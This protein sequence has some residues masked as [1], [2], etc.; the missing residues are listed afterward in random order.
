M[1][2]AFLLAAAQ[3]Q[4]A[5][6]PPDIVVT[7]RPLDATER[8]L[9]ECIARHCPPE[10]DMRATLAHAENQF[11]AGKYEGSQQTLGASIS[12]NKRF[13]KT[14]PVAV[15]DVMRAKGRID[16]HLG[17]ASLARIG[18][19]ESLGALRA[20]LPA[21]DPRVLA[22]RIEVADADARLGRAEFALDAYAQ[23]ADD[24]H[25]ANA[26]VVEGYA[27]LRRVVLLVVMSEVDGGYERDL[28][29]AVKWYDTPER[30]ALAQFRAAAELM[31]AQH[32]MRKGDPAAI[33]AMIARYSHATARPQLLYQ[34]VKPQQDSGRAT[35]GGSVTNQIAIGNYD[36]QWV[37]ISF[38]VTPEGKVSDVSTLRASPKLSGDWVKPIVA[39][40]AE[41]RY[42][43]LQMDKTEP[44]A[45]R[46]ERYTLTA[47]WLQDT[48]GSRIRQREAIPRIEMVDLT[49]DPRPAP[50][51]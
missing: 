50:K 14:L 1:I 36:D 42:A 32:A 34:P 35:A 19:I 10:E 6:A 22:Q 9:A 3:A 25:A 31:A 33:D 28:R 5:A 24:A 45:L 23:I 4:T 18:S 21:S 8:A 49:D 27:R 40:I 39:T 51:S 7:G 17:E 46:V 15:S 41:R 38:W 13:A 20:G 16:L 29:T 12:R 43:P 30:A 26:P 47:H 11:V 2:L 44:G 48:T 37:D